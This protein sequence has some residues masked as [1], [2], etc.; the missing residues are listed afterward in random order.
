M[1]DADVVSLTGIKSKGAE[2]IEKTLLFSPRNVA[3][4]LW[5][6]SHYIADAHMPFHCDNRALASTAKQKTHGKVED[7]WGEQ[8]SD[9]FHSKTILSKSADDIL[10][11][12]PQQVLNSLTSTL[13]VQ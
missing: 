13:E 4:T 1:G 2:N 10:F 11:P 6:A 8:V 7:L 3:M 5:M 9:L 12:I